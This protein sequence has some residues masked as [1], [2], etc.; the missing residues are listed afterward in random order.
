MTEKLDASR[1]VREGLSCTI[2]IAVLSN[3]YGGPNLSFTIGNTSFWRL[4]ENPDQLQEMGNEVLNECWT[5]VGEAAARHLNPGKGV[6]T[7]LL[8]IPVVYIDTRAR[9]VDI[10]FFHQVNSSKDGTPR[11]SDPLAPV[12]TT[13]ADLGVLEPLRSINLFG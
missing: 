1:A 3:K 7:Q 5:V 4:D 10:H 9:D 11:F 2:A 8:W 12:I 6:I 13:D